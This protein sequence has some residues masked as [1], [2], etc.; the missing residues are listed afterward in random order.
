[1]ARKQKISVEEKVKLVRDCMNGRISISEVARRARVARET[2]KDWLNSY[3][4]EGI[5]GFIYTKNKAYSVELKE[6]AVLAYLRGEG[7][8]QDISKKYGIRGTRPLRSWIK[9]YNAHGDFNTAKHSGGG[10]KSG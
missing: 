1:M 5:D 4:N 8:L 9:V 2:V 7:S 3:E 10:R 6:S